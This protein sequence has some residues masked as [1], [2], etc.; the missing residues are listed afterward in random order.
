MKTQQDH[1]TKTV[2]K[3]VVSFPW[4]VGDF[5]SLFLIETFL[6]KDELV[7]LVNITTDNCDLNGKYVVP[8][9]LSIVGDVTGE[10]IRE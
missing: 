2:V 5:V 9:Y 8:E 7:S 4:A 1:K 6:I 3:N 10:F